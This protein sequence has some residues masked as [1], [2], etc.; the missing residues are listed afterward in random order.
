MAP[1]QLTTVIQCTIY[2][3]KFLFYENQ[4]NWTY[5][6]INKNEWINNNTDVFRVCKLIQD[7]AQIIFIT[8]SGIMI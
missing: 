3:S 6:H 8:L 5:K 2:T 1:K 7:H 4:Y